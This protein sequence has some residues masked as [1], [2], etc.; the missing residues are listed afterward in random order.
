MF[1]ILIAA[2]WPIWFLLLTSIVAVA[3]II[4]RFIALQ[5]NKIIPPG[6]LMDVL[7]LHQNNQV[8]P[9]VL[10]KLR[11]NSPFGQ[12]LAVGLQNAGASREVLKSAIE[13]VG[14]HVAHKLSRFLNTI[15]T[16]A[17]A[18][19][20]MGL[21][22]T[23]VGM[24]EI[25]GATGGTGGTANVAQLGHGISVALY[26]TGFG[27]LIAIPALIA[28][29]YFRG[30]VDDLVMEMEQQVVRLIDVVQGVRK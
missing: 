2:G 15:G 4:E 11:T 18:A 13:D 29:R 12:I 9:E 24:I 19:P 1:A 7:N 23:V 10:A 20:L 6:L 30:K 21:F 16:I 5:Q 27:I 17:S 22:G 3:L 26:N 25:F 8:T 28:Y 14:S